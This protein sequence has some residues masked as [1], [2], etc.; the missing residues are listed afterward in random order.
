MD[1]A[2][3]VIKSS[4]YG[5][6][7][8][9]KD[10]LSMTLPELEKETE[11]L[12]EKKFRAKQI[13]SWLHEH[14][15]QSFDEMTNISKSL[16]DKLESGCAILHTSIE[17]KLCS[18]Y[19]NTKKYLLKLDDG[20][21]IESVLMRYK[22]GQTV[23]VST[24]VGCAMGCKFCASTLDGCVRNLT[25]SEILCQVYSAERDSG[26][27]ISHIVLMGMGEPLENYDNVLRFLELVTA[28]NGKNISMRHISISTCGI[29][30]RIYDLMQKN[31]QLTLSV[32]LHAPNDEIRKKMMPIA[33]K[34]SIAE[35]LKACED[36]EKKTHRRISFEYA[37]VKDV[38][39]SED[40]ARE[41][42]GRLNGTLCHVNLIPVNEVRETGM[43][44]SDE[45]TVE[46]FS[47]ILK[48]RNIAV[49]VRRK[50]GSDIN[51]SCGQ[52]RRNFSSK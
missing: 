4:K 36:Y 34:Y 7:Q 30:P 5:Q 42:A 15:V 21:Y 40:C 44:K 35:L 48:S 38:N 28:E 18:E 20:E 27:K 16:R 13:F 12:G 52:L 39:D 25:P 22:Y 45:K 19:D 17:K 24:Q 49:T 11:A 10:I 31:L 33:R 6:A 47:E 2:D 41:L 8:G 1:M 37:M 50:L 23:C 51:A 9:K 32:S 46:K 43:K 29:V 26:E 14:S 3:Y